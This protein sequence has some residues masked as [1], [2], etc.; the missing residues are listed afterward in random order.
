MLIAARVVVSFLFLFSGAWAAL[1]GG[2]GATN[3]REAHPGPIGYLAGPCWWA[4][5][6]THPLAIYRIWIGDSI[7]LWLGVIAT[8]QMLFFAIFGRNLSTE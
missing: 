4:L 7:W 1:P 3:F 2:F 6:L 8:M 5:L